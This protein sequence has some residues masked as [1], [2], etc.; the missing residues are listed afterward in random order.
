M[1]DYWNP[2]GEPVEDSDLDR[3]TDEWLDSACGDV[4][5]AGYKFATSRALKELD[6]LA[7]REQQDLMVYAMVRRGELLDEEPE[8]CPE[9]G[10]LGYDSP[11]DCTFCADKEESEEEE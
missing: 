1:A 7:W 4:D 8:L 10:E 2:D 9:C 6:Y 5:V 3:M 11:D